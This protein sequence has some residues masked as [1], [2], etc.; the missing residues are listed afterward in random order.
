VSPALILERVE[1][2]IHKNSRLARR[3]TLSI[4]IHHFI[5]ELGYG[6]AFCVYLCVG[7]CVNVESKQMPRRD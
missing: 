5:P 3:S 2:Y 6:P 7:A 4:N 1:I